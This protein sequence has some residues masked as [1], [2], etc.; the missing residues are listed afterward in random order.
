MDEGQV[1][2]RFFI[3]GSLAA[4]IVI[5]PSLDDAAAPEIIMVAA[6]RVVRKRIDDVLVWESKGFSVTRLVGLFDLDKD[7]VGE[8]VALGRLASGDAAAFIL[9]SVDGSLLWNSAPGDVGQLRDTAR[10]VDMTGDGFL[11]LYLADAGTN[12]PG[13]IPY[14][15]HLYTFAE[16]IPSGQKAWSMSKS[17]GR[18]YFVSLMDAVGDLDGDGGM[19]IF[20]QGLKKVYVY[21][22]SDG[23]LKGSFASGNTAAGRSEVVLVD[24]D[25]DKDKEIVTFS[26]GGWA[27][28][29]VQLL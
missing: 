5:V 28:Q 24:L 19:E 29:L 16:G 2:W 26:P 8:L 11:D 22:G 10:V 20:V 12:L 23:T 13:S 17:P 7:G 3:G 21:S 9:S 14:G 4:Q 27:H 25:G 18:D 15:V 1:S 6:N